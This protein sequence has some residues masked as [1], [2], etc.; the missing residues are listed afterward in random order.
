[1]LAFWII[2]IIGWFMRRTLWR[3][4]AMGPPSGALTGRDE[5]ASGAAPPG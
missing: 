2:E 4:P 1:M 3:R 5:P